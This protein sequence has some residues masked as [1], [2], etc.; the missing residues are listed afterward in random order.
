VISKNFLGLYVL[1][2]DGVKRGIG[3]ERVR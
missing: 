2:V 3:V 1:T